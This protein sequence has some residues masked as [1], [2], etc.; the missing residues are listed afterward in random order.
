[1]TDVPK[2][3]VFYDQSG[4]GRIKYAIF[5]ALGI[6]GIEGSKGFQRHNEKFVFGPR[7]EIPLRT[8]GLAKRLARKFARRQK[9]GAKC[10]LNG[11]E[12]D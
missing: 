9:R 4:L 7:L 12:D 11:D 1:V 8:M 2:F 6:D 10:A 5:S 3:F